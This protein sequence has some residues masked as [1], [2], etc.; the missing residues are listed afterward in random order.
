MMK[1]AE[2]SMQSW[3][4]AVKALVFRLEQARIDMSEQDIILALTMGLP[5][6]YDAVIINFDATAPELLTLDH[7]ITH[8]LNEETH[9]ESGKET[10]KTEPEDEA[11][12]VTHSTGR[13][14]EK[15]KMS[16]FRRHLLLV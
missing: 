8:L 1:K 9:Q 15:N 12:V 10:I 3:I 13:H 14:C 2:E 11:M 7:V 5:V 4:G 16:N 6:A